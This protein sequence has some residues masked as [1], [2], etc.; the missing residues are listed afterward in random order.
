[1]CTGFYETTAHAA[2]QQAVFVVF[3]CKLSLL[4]INKSVST[5][6]TLQTTSVM[7]TENQL[8]RAHCVFESLFKALLLLLNG[9]STVKMHMSGF[10][11]LRYIYRF[12]CIQL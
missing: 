7:L 8:T 2:I 5:V 9:F 1:M 12:F 10:F 6:E 3:F 4:F 11:F